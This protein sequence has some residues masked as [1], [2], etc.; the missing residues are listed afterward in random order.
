MQF[1]ADADIYMYFCGHTR[2]THTFALQCSRQSM[3]VLLNIELDL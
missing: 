3:N 2:L 1:G